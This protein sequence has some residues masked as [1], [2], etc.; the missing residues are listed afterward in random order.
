M[1][2]KCGLWRRHIVSASLQHQQPGPARMPCSSW[3]EKAPQE[4][5][6]PVIIQDYFRATFFHNPLEQE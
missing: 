6:I 1:V 3:H 5:H 2:A 4:R